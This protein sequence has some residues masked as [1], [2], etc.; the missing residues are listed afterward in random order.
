ME[1]NKLAV[2]IGLNGAGKSQLL[3]SISSGSI[4]TSYGLNNLSNDIKLLTNEDD[5]TNS[6]LG[7]SSTD[8]RT[9]LNIPVRD[10]EKSSIVNAILHQQKVEIGALEAQLLELTGNLSTDLNVNW[11]ALV[12][13]MLFHRTS[14]ITSHSPDLT[15]L[16]GPARDAAN[17]LAVMIAG[18]AAVHLGPTGRFLTITRDEVCQTKG[19]NETQFFTPDLVRVFSEY[20][21]RRW[22]NQVQRQTD[23]D[24]GTGEALTNEEFIEQYGPPPWDRVTFALNQFGLPYTVIQPSSN[25]AGE[26]SFKLRRTDKSAEI[27]FQQLSSGERVLLRMMLAMFQAQDERL[28]VRYPKLVLLDELDASLHPQNVQRWLSSIQRDYVE[29][30]DISCILTTHS[31]TTVALAPDDA[32]YELTEETSQPVKVTKQYALDRLTAG[33]PMLAISYSNRRQVFT[34]S[35]IDVDHYSMLHDLMR[36]KLELQRTLSF[37]GTSTKG[38]CN[39]VYDMVK[40]MEDNGNRSV[41]GIVDWDLRNRP[42]QRVKV[43]ADGTH[44]AKDN[45]LLD[46]LLIA[47]LLLKDDDLGIQPPIRYSNLGNCSII[48]LQRL[49]DYIVN[50]TPVPKVSSNDVTYNQYFGGFNLGVKASYILRQGHEL[51]RSIKSAFPMLDGRYR[52]EGAL[53]TEIISRVLGDYPKFCPKPVCDLFLA[54]SNDS[55]EA[56]N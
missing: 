13:G 19:W 26:V 21:D 35:S 14:A 31:P 42:N 2:I 27:G 1:L 53:I 51:E 41:F 48:E 23:Q 7:S 11:S 10:A 34:E 18:P 52:A 30:L 8:L 43:I 25:P 55:P 17:R 4:L 39:F 5:D 56:L 20:R 37:V 49:S 22:R 44:Y 46:P 38:S 15:S 40:H 6:L 45:V 50:K 36:P 32:I 12:D 28:N 33:L 29:T 47:A 24:D 16:V 54:L 3:K 9:I